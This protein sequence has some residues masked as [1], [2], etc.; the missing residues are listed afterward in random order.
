ML[1]FVFVRVGMAIPTLLF[2]SIA[3]FVLVRM[4][5][6]DPAQLLLGDLADPDSLADMRQ[7]M[8]LD[9][10]VL[11]QFVIWFGNLLTGDLGRSITTGQDVTALV[12]SRFLISAQVVLAAVLFAALV[13]VPAGIIAAWRQNGA[14]DLVLIGAATLLV[15]IPTFWLG[16]LMLLLFGV[17]LSWLPVVGYVPFSQDAMGAVLYLLMPIAT[18]FL[19]EIGILIRMSRASPRTRLM[20][21]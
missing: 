19:H 17:K 21:V 8:G 1:R 10:S 15:S 20:L 6:G 9:K 18:L 5:P 16:L 4:I 2:V 3:V 7:R 13:A 12:S 11:Q 14:T